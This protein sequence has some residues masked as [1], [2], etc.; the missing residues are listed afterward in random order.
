PQRPAGSESSFHLGAV[1]APHAET[2]AGNDPHDQQP[3]VGCRHSGDFA[4]VR[5]AIVVVHVVQAAVV[6]DQLQ[7]AGDPGL[8][9]LPDVSVDEVDGDVVDARLG[10]RLLQRGRY[11]IHGRDLPTLLGQINRAVAGTATQF[12]CGTRRERGG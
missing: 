1:D 11:E 5:I 3:R 2:P 10:P 4:D 9:Q 7:W 6:D 8:T 12:E